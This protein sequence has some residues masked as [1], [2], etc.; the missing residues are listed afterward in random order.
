MKKTIK[1]TEAD[2][3]KMVKRIIAENQLDEVAEEPVLDNA[4]LSIGLAFGEGQSNLSST[5]KNEIIS[6]L[7]DFIRNYPQTIKTLAQFYK[8][9]NIPKFITINVGTSH[10][11]TPEAN[12]RVAQARM[13]TMESLIAGVF[14]KYGI[15]AEV[16]RQFITNNTE[17]NYKPSS[18]DKNFYDPKKVAPDS[19]E[20]MGVL[21]IQP[22]T[23][24]GL[25]TSGIQGVQ[26]GLNM[27]S[28][29]VNNIFIDGVNEVALVQFIKKL[30]TFS[31]VQDLS[32]AIDA[33]GK[34]NSLEEFLNDQL[35][36]DPEEMRQIAQH[37]K[38]C[39]TTSGKQADT[40]RLYGSTTGYRISIGLG[41]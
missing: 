41:L 16:I 17:K 21:T 9:G 25:N 31:D 30:Q 32:R 14:G 35:F 38:R 22:L 24:K 20:R 26:K 33:G 15:S 5:G 2:I 34:W 4:G 3:L 23:T 6:F 29:D 40:V 8:S 7:T 27:F 39:A 36:D 11:G 13:K 28:S 18:L 10:T 19:N 1:L 37:L 12:D